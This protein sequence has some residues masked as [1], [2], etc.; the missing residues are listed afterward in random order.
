[1]DFVTTACWAAGTRRPRSSSL[2]STSKNW[3][4]VA[5][6]RTANATEQAVRLNPGSLGGTRQRRR[7]CIPWQRSQSTWRRCAM[8]WRRTCPGQSARRIITADVRPTTSGTSWRSLPD[9]THPSLKQWKG[10]AFKQTG[11]ILGPP[12]RSQL[13]RQDSREMRGLRRWIPRRWRPRRRGRERENNECIG[14][15]RSP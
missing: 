10:E 9:P 7:L 2:T 6:T 15:L 14:G 3:R 4:S 11:R 8:P 12:A 13:I 5:Q 1:M